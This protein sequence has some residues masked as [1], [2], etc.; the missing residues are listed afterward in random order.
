MS[1][2]RDGIRQ[3]H[4]EAGGLLELQVVQRADMSALILDA[5]A[6]SDEAAQLLRLTQDTL[7]KIKAAPRR[8]PML[9][10]ACPRALQGGRFA[11]IIAK[12]SCDDPTQGI[13]MAICTRCGP[14]LPGIQA[15]A[16]TALQ[17]IWPDLRPVVVTHPKGGRA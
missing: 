7:A 8:E 13:A 6:G 15:A 5:L 2:L 1:A 4:V 10:G 16:R 9:C 11:I 3:V 14:N 17:R 12:P